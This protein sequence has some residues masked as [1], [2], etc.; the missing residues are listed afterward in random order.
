[1]AA[2]RAAVSSVGSDVTGADQDWCAGSPG[3]C[4][5]PA[6]SG[7]SAACRACSTCPPACALLAPLAAWRLPASTM[8]AAQLPPSVTWQATA[9]LLASHNS[10]HLH[11]ISCT[12]EHT[13]DYEL[14]ITG[15]NYNSYAEDWVAKRY[16]ADR[17]HDEGLHACLGAVAVLLAEAWVDDILHG[18][19]CLAMRTHT[20]CSLP[21]VSG[22]Q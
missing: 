18:T 3:W 2:C 7:M 11:K 4:C 19:Q 21:Q 8:T 17:C 15:L 9:C 1:M 6:Q 22:V 20:C 12:P 10:S 16:L 14:P 5:P 13:Q